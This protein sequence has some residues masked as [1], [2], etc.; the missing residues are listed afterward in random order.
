[1]LWL[2]CCLSKLNNIL[3]LVFLLLSSI[4]LWWLLYLLLKRRFRW[5]LLPIKQFPTQF[6]RW[7][8]ITELSF[9]DRTVERVLLLK[10]YFKDRFC[11]KLRWF[12]LLNLHFD[13]F[14]E[15]NI[16][17]SLSFLINQNSSPTKQC[18]MTCNM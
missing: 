14:L 10:G 16:G 15:A 5:V 4:F 11:S 3:F 7:L 13:G 12:E 6:W 2:Y 9:P 1:M 17:L 8:C 18:H